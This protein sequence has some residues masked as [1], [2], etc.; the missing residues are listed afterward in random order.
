MSYSVETISTFETG[1]KSLIKDYIRLINKER[2][3]RNIS[4][5]FLEEASATVM[6]L[7]MDPDASANDFDPFFDFDRG[8]DVPFLVRSSRILPAALLSAC[9]I[10]MNTSRNTSMTYSVL[11]KKL[12]QC[13]SMKPDFR[14]IGITRVCLKKRSKKL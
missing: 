4:E 14:H 13:F 3:D 12:Q 8:R 7:I 11:T 2:Y 6:E 10:I 5:E 9:L 1:L